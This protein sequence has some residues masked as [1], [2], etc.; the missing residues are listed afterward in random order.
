MSAKHPSDTELV[1]E[2]VKD[3]GRNQETLAILVKKVESESKT[4]L[5]PIAQS[6]LKLLR[7]SVLIADVKSQ[8]GKI[9]MISNVLD[10]ICSPTQLPKG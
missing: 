10:E 2:L 8:T 9:E 7:R 6:K 3:F 4:N 5:D 1:N